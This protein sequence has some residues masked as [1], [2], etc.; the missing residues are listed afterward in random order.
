MCH[1][2][3]GTYSGYISKN[4]KR[5][6]KISWFRWL[7]RYQISESAILGAVSLGLGLATG[8]GVWA[9]K[10]MIHLSHNFF[11]GFLGGY[12]QTHGVWTLAL[13][14]ILGGLV[15]GLVQTYLIGPERH[16]GVAGIIESVA[17]SG[18]R[19]R[20]WRVP[21][22]AIASAIS[23]G[24]GGSVGPEDPSVQIGSNLGSMFGSLLK[25]SEDR[26]RTLVAAGAAGGIASA[27]NAP[28]AGVFF[29]VEIILGE[30]GTSSLGVVVL[31][32]VI[33]SVFTQAVSGVQ[34]AFS[35][36]SYSF[37]TIWQLP[38][39]FVLGA[40]AGP[41]S[42]LY[43]KALYWFQ[44]FFHHMKTPNWVKPAIAGLAV[45][46]VGLVLP[47]ILG[48]G[49]DSIGNVLNGSLNGILIL[50]ALT[51]AK[52]LMTSV[53]IG[54]GF[55]GGVFAP[56]LFIGAMLGA[57][58]GAVAKMMFPTLYI[59]PAAFAM[60]G[61]A[62]VLAGAVHSPLTAILLLFEM[63]HDYRIILPL[64]FSVIISLLISRHIAS[65]SVYMLGLARKGIRI[66]RGRDV[67]VLER[68]TVGEV[69]TESPPVLH[70]DMT[71]KEAIEFLTKN[72]IHG[73]PVV[74]T[75]GELVGVATRH[76]V[77]D[78]DRDENE[79]VG[80]FC[81]RDL[82]VTYPDETIGAALERMSVRDIGRMPVVSHENPK[83]LVGLLRR[84][85]AIRAYDL[86]L[87]KRA[88]LRHRAHQVRLGTFSGVDVQ[89]IVIQSGAACDGQAVQDV[90]WPRDCVIASVRRGIKLFIPRGETILKAG[91]VLVFVAEGD[92]RQTVETLCREKSE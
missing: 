68:I 2:F 48:E 45:G 30:I 51:I 47:Q 19:L 7:D 77:G 29:A 54:G 21:A 85:D 80:D 62:A 38:L 27:F 83:I 10:E 18:G 13:L 3:C 60:V 63:T 76:D 50:F 61:M 64:M 25:M 20:Y 58:F 84:S 88:L 92:A 40:I 89:E 41:L 34:P 70:E 22:K 65:D 46:I 55:A 35:V 26:V 32:A 24:S 59:V 5:Y 71:V 4:R 86:A 82:F 16:H 52:L 11:N 36:P 15:V 75:T 67:E 33:A 23:I 72:R 69:M 56:A 17:L 91:D 31:S 49:Y 44:D 43:V 73:V 39:Y 74:S 37:D 53:S 57:G 9:F 8:I 81:A 78:S 66:E 28:I 90:A 6:M 42:A 87:K 12:L 14:P 79:R 1:S